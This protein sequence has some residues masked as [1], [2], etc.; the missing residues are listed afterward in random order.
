MTGEVGADGRFR[1]VGGV[2]LSDTEH[3]TTPDFTSFLWVVQILLNSLLS[4]LGGANLIEHKTEESIGLGGWD[5]LVLLGF[6]VSSEEQFPVRSSPLSSFL[7]SATFKSLL[8]VPWPA[9]VTSDNTTK[10]PV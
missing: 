8:K 10:C 1:M 6:Q 7:P 3:L 5:F 9:M 4:L 2:S